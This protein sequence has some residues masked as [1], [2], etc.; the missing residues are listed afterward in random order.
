[1]FNI[2]KFINA[3]KCLWLRRITKTNSISISLFKEDICNVKYL[4][5]F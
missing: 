4:M 1:M 3:L 5:H 2:E